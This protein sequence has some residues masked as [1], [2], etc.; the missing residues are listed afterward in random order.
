VILYTGVTVSFDLVY[1]IV[2]EIFPTIF[3][4]TAYGACNVI[5]RFIS[6]LAPQLAVLPGLW[7]MGILAIYGVL[8]TALPFGLITTGKK[9]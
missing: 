8:G 1:L 2:N 3:R 4:G 6:I 7:C 9:Q 5:G